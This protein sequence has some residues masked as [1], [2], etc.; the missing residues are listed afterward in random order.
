VAMYRGERQEEITE[1]GFGKL[2]RR[3]DLGQKR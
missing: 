3:Q 1:I 2:V